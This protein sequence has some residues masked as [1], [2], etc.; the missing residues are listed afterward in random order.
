MSSNFFLT[1]S[2]QISTNFLAGFSF[3]AADKTTLSKIPKGPTTLKASTSSVSHGNPPCKIDPKDRL[4][5]CPLVWS[6]LEKDKLLWS[7]RA[8]GGLSVP[9]GAHQGGC[10]FPQNS[11]RL[12]C[13]GVG[14]GGLGSRG[15]TG[16]CSFEVH[17]SVDPGCSQNKSGGLI[18]A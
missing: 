2:S 12:A 9:S 8:P 13:W 15:G 14:R 5:V 7:E 17:I 3:Y 18:L 6:G 11:P 1:S 4:Y 10:G 16:G